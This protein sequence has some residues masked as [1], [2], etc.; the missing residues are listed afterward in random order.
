MQITNISAGPRGVNGKDGPVLIDPKQTVEVELSEAELKVS[1]ATG[2]FTFDGESVKDDS[3]P[4]ERDELKKQADELG[5]TYAGNISNAKL[6][7][8]IDAKL[9]E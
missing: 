4:S 3:K 5:L 7:E 8:M 2:W 9:A 1:K 6:K